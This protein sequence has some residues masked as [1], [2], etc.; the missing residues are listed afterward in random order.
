MAYFSV[1]STECFVPYGEEW[2]IDRIKQL[3]LCVERDVQE[4]GKVKKTKN[5]LTWAWKYGHRNKFANINH[6][7]LYTLLADP[8]HIHAIHRVS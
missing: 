2:K 8:Y 4:R 6:G 7:Y 5:E 3:H 1:L